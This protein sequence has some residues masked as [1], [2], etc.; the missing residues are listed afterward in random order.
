MVTD[1]GGAIVVED[2]LTKL[3]DYG[4]GV[5]IAYMV[6]TRVIHKLD[7]IEQCLRE[8]KLRLERNG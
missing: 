8:L 4:V 5:F 7:Q 1:Q 6:I 2:I 3:M